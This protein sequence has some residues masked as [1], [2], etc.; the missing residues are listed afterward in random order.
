MSLETYNTAEKRV[1]G[2]FRH[3]TDK[4]V[5]ENN[6]PIKFKEW[7]LTKRT[8]SDDVQRVS[9]QETAGTSIQSVRVSREIAPIKDWAPAKKGTNAKFSG[10]MTQDFPELQKLNDDQVDR[11]VNSVRRREIED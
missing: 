8:Y 4:L 6:R 10:I 1:K 3:G 9:N 2:F 5:D 11:I 7:N